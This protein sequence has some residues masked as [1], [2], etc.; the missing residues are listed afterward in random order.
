MR[1]D[2]FISRD[3]EFEGERIILEREGDLN[4]WHGRTKEGELIVVDQY[5]HNIKKA[6]KIRGFTWKINE[7]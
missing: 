4:K 6:L 7:D 5:R 2:N 3:P 1:T